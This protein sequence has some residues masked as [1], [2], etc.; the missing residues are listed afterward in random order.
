ML[1][2]LYERNTYSP[3]GVPCDSMAVAVLSADSVAAVHTPCGFCDSSVGHS[4]VC[5]VLE[6]VYQEMNL[7]EG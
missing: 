5:S 1:S 6:E 2:T 3:A 7:K 4:S